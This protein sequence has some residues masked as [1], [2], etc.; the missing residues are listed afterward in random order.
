[1]TMEN[2]VWSATLGIVASAPFLLFV[3]AFG[4]LAKYSLMPSDPAPGAAIGLE[5]YQKIFFD[6][7]Y[8]SI[9]GNTLKLSIVVTV[10]ALVLGYPVAYA[11]ATSRL[12]D[13]LLFLVVLPMLADI[14]V[15]AYGWIV[16]LSSGGVVNSALLAWGIIASPVRMFPSEFAVGIALLHEVLPFAILPV[17]ASLR[18]IN[19]NLREAALLLYAN[20]WR[21]FLA[22]TLPLSMPGILAGSLLTLAMCISTF[23]VPLLLGGGT[24]RMVSMA[25]SEQV[26]VTL[27]WPLGSALVVVLVALVCAL[28]YGYSVATG[29]IGSDK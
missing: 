15:R 21:A 19:P 26:T 18:K 22:V 4:I 9:L 8:L 13:V 17:A 23:A 10:L 5:S 16:I 14:L 1:M 6:P 12:G 27:N 25:I 29:R 28:T 7:Y 20:E 11:I 3:V 24:V 2:R